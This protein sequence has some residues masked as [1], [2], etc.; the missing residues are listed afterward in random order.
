ML[1]DIAIF[2]VTIQ[3]L[4][5][6]TAVFWDVTPCCLVQK[7][8]TFR[9]N[10][11]QI[12]PKKKSQYLATK[13]H[14]FTF[15][16]TVIMKY[17]LVLIARFSVESLKVR[18]NQDCACYET[19]TNF[20]LNTNV[21]YNFEHTCYLV[22]RKHLTGGFVDC[23]DVQCKAAAAAA[24]LFPRGYLCHR[25]CLET[26]LHSEPDM[27]VSLRESPW[28]FQPPYSPDHNAPEPNTRLTFQRKECF[29]LGPLG[30]VLRKYK[31]SVFS[32]S[33]RYQNV[34]CYL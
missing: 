14:G 7:K 27:T 13:L 1:L 6:K 32:V 23:Q 34:N 20:P 9:T 31:F 19:D 16:K 2:V 17:V 25:L 12:V 29:W 28:R 33:M 30:L 4:G 11:G 8:L 22:E 5:E 21:G 18:L 10:L 15:K 24:L 26:V 3:V